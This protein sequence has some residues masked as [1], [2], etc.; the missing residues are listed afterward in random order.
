M[1][2]NQKKN[3]LW[4]I[5]S[6]LTDYQI[7]SFF[8]AIHNQETNQ[9]DLSAIFKKIDVEHCIELTNDIV[10]CTGQFNQCYKEVLIENSKRKRGDDTDGI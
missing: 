2:E 8:R 9:N 6:E 10:S 5:L 3:E 4:K 7:V 1:L